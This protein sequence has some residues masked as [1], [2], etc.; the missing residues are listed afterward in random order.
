MKIRA[1]DLELR[2]ED[3]PLFLPHLLLEAYIR[4]WK[5]KGFGLVCLPH[6]A[7]ISN[8]LLT[9]ELNSLGLHYIQNT[10]CRIQPCGTELLLDSC[11]FLSQITIVV[12]VGLHSES[13]SQKIPLYV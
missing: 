13:H 9:L 3:T 4:A 1:F 10:S 5:Y 6:L 7:I 2:W 8:P 12:L 11:T